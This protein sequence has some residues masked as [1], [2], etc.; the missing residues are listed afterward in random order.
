M[1]RF[2]M[3]GLTAALTMTACNGSTDDETETETETESEVLPPEI[4]ISGMTAELFT[5][6]PAGTSHCVDAVDPAA[7]LEGGA[8][9]VLG[10][11]TVNADGSYS[12]E[13]VDISKA[14]L[15]IFLIL[16]DCDAEDGS[17]FP[18][19]TGFSPDTYGTAQRGDELTSTVLYISSTTEAGLNGSLAAIGSTATLDDGA[20]MGFVFN[21]E[22]R[23]AGATVTCT[24]CGPTYYVDADP[25]DGLL[26][27]A[28]NIN[29]A[30]MPGVGLAFIP[31]GPVAAYA[32][33]HDDL[34]FEPGLF[35]SL[36]GI[37]A[38]TAWRASAE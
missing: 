16:R 10:T 27:T 5:Q 28:G 21:G 12:V 22:T 24:G 6:A 32:V 8:L 38:F 19:A 23:V 33:S 25:T 1:Q 37:V 30:T 17:V 7:A 35:G 11:T 13:G 29:E 2:W 18:S 14:P 15:A 3:M 36:P 34:N 9:N 20:I 31:S 4:T 26:S